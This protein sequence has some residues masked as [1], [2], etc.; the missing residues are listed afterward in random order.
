MI[1]NL[2]K[3]NEKFIK[4][5]AFSY[6]VIL[7]NI[8]SSIIVVKYN[9]HVF[10]KELY[11]L[12]IITFSIV[13]L[14]SLFNLGFNS[15]LIFKFAQYKKLKALNTLFN[16]NVIVAVFQISLTIVSFILIY[17]Y[18]FKFFID[19]SNFSNFKSLLLIMLPGL[20]CTIIS[21]FFESIL[22]YNLRFIYFKNLLELFRLGFLNIGFVIGLYFWQNI[23]V[24]A[25]SYS[26]ISFLILIYVIFKFKKNQ[27][28]SF[29]LKEGKLSYI[30]ENFNNAISFWILT[31]SSVVISQSDGLF[32]SSI[33]KDLGLV[34]LYSQSFRLQDI[35]LKFIKKITEIK[36][37]K[38]LG[39]YTEG[40]HNVIIRIYK[41]LFSLNLILSVIS[42]IIIS[43]TGKQI[44]E[45]WL[46][47]EIIFDQKLIVS[48]S[49][50][51]ISGSLHWV[52]WNFASITEQQKKIKNISLMEIFLNLT[53][54]YFL[55]HK[56][57]IIGLGIASLIS[58]TFTVLY[59]IYL[60]KKY[61][62]KW[63][64]LK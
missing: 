55:L 38:L 9:L 1:R 37:P 35:V 23:K 29:N 42:F 28:F 36:G 62:K 17:F 16:S 53:L 61:E 27:Q 3:S 13:N 21:S 14:L 56:I 8:V 24:L 7:F 59:G 4:H 18:L 41:Q 49:L 45:F 57:G 20:I 52:I 47:Y 46:N 25:I 44:L 22:Y 10:K 12:W 60:F 50:L 26:I 34:T 5:S 40:K 11:G 54:S 15:V 19:F 48:L 33:K 32:I 31:F 30:N 51:C 39:L 2:I 6:L 58:N 64:H 63:Q 43:F